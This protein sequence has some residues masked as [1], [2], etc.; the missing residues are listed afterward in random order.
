MS[1]RIMSW[2]MSQVSMSHVTGLNESCHRSQWVMS[3]LNIIPKFLPPLHPLVMN[4]VA[5][6][7][8]V[9]QV[10][11]GCCRVLQGAAVCC[12]VLQWEAQ[13]SSH[14]FIVSIH[15]AW[16]SL[17]RICV[18]KQSHAWSICIRV[19]FLRGLQ[20]LL[21]CR[22]ASFP[23]PCS[24]SWRIL[25]RDAF[26]FGRHS[27]LWRTFI[28]DS[29][30]FLGEFEQL[31]LCRGAWVPPVDPYTFG[32]QNCCRTKTAKET[33]ANMQTRPVRI[34]NEKQRPMGLFAKETYA[35]ILILAK[36]T[37]ENIQWDLYEWAN[38]TCEDAWI[39]KKDLWRFIRDSSHAWHT[40]LADTNGALV[41]VTVY[42]QE[43]TV[44]KTLIHT[45]KRTILRKKRPIHTQKRRM[46][47]QKGP[48]RM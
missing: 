46:H 2:V 37:F 20:Q 26:S 44:Y 3:R 39:G 33:Y 15:R 22:G 9:L 12:S 14:W 6:S 10:V 40:S 17:I 1:H 41:C 31:L 23:I 43:R 27:P 34:C 4:F 36:E 42:T 11:A 35:N 16:I 21:L 38:G 24:H 19:S 29:L 45:Q 8:N 48:M 7:C 18:V 30:S 47:T 25:I 28:R 32:S 5:A 13:L